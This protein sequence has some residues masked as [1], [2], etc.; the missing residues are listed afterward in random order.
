MGRIRSNT[1][2]DPAHCFAALSLLIISSIWLFGH[3]LEGRDIILAMLVATMYSTILNFAGYVR[4]P[5]A[6]GV[7]LSSLW[8]ISPV[9]LLDWNEKWQQWP[10]PTMVALSSGAILFAVSCMVFHDVK[11]ED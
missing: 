5:T 4:L 8:I 10:F 9:Y 11:L 6:I 1:G 2:D 3:D 7:I